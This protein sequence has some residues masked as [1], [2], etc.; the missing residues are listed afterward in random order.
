M[1][2]SIVEIIRRFEC[3][4]TSYSSKEEEL[5]CSLNN[6]LV[7]Q[8]YLAK[9]FRRDV[10]ELKRSQ[11]EHL[12]KLDIHSKPL[13]FD[14]LVQEQIQKLY[15]YRHLDD[16]DDDEDETQNERTL[17]TDEFDKLHDEHFQWIKKKKKDAKTNGPVL[18]RYRELKQKSK[19]KL[20]K[21]IFFFRRTS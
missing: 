11:Q 1:K 10:D 19:R 21:L 14:E 2:S 3:L 5:S 9:T 7:D 12:S 4:E 6:F 17:N 13:S 18:E 16:E 8:T 20:F 15:H